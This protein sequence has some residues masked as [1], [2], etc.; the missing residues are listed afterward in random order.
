MKGFEVEMYVQDSN[1]PHYA[2]G[3]YSVMNNEWIKEPSRWRKEIDFETVQKKAANLMDEIDNVYEYYAEKDYRTAN[4]MADHLMDRIRKYRKAGLSSGGIN[5]VE[6]LSFKVLRRNEY[7]KK[8][9]S[10]RILSYDA[11]M[12]VKQ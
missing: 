5:S 2:S 8:L 3:I 4:K 12:S 10:L 11:M 7:I 6:N 9:N 1:E